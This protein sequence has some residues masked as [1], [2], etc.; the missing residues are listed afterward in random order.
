M[1]IVQRSDTGHRSPWATD[2]DAKRYIGCLGRVVPITSHTFR[3]Y[4]NSGEQL[5]ATIVR[6]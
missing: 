5:T 2:R 1:W 3:V 4:L 6:G